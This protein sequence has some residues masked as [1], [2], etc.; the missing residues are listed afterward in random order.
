MLYEERTISLKPGMVGEFLRWSR[1]DHRS[2]VHD[3]GGRVLCVMGGLIG[4]QA[5]E[6]LQITRFPDFDSWQRL[7]TIVA[8]KRA[9]LVESEE[10]RL[11]RAIAARPKEALPDE[12]RRAVYGYRRFFTRG[13]DL[14]E[15]VYCSGEGV[16]PRFEAQDAC[17]L[18]LWTTM[19]ATDPQ[20]VVLLTGYHGPGHWEETRG[21]LP[22][23]EGFDPELWERG[24]VLG[25]RRGQL[26]LK[27]WVKL[28][29]AIELDEKANQAG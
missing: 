25:A 11:L 3:H 18:G 5:S 26:T 28:L 23:P 21:N 24:R 19:A 15:F 22:M 12:D 13:S 2:I 27:S 6:L 8:P 9:E 17:I 16:W 29:R 1:Q 10:V 4:S 20:E 7:Q 14:D